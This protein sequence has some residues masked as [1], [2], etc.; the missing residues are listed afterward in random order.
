VRGKALC[1]CDLMLHVYVKDLVRGDSMGSC[2]RL[3]Q[4]HVYLVDH[5]SCY[6]QLTV[7]LIQFALK[8]ENKRIRRCLTGEWKMRK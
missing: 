2:S 8:V 4:T 7:H 5:W 1:I 3:N 6:L